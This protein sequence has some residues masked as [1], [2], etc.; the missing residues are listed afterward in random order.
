MKNEVILCLK[1]WLW[2]RKQGAG[3]EARF[4]WGMR[5]AMGVPLPTK[6]DFSYRITMTWK[7]GS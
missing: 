7:A 5:V 1:I 4:E 6:A 2:R 3:M